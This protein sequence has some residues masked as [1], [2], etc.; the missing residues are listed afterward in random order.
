[1]LS[2][3]RLFVRETILESL[4]TSSHKKLRVFDFDDTL[5]KTKSIIRATSANGEKFELTPGE[6]AVYT[7]NSGDSFDYSDFDKLI[8]PVEIK[9]TAKILKNIVSAGSEV[10]IL[11][12]RA[13]QEPVKQFLQDAGLPPLEVIALGSSDPIKKSDYI[14]NRIKSDGITW[15]EFFDDSQKNVQAVKN[16]NVKYPDVKIISRHITHRDF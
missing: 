15:I 10:V 8:N 11:T 2:Q 5:V 13:A 9:W 6:Y 14:E 7:P 12:A 1:M 3:L 4:R 16:L